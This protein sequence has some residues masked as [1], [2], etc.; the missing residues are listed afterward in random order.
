MS[1]GRRTY[2]VQAGPA[3]SEREGEI[4]RLVVHSFIET[5]GP[6]GSSFLANRYG[7]GLSTA[8]IRNTLSGLEARGFLNHPYTSAGRVPTDLG[9][10]TFV[11]R[12]MQAT[13]LSQR[14]QQVMESVVARADALN[15]GYLRECSRLLGRFSNL[16]GVV[17]SPN[18]ATGIL[19]RLEVV[20]V[21][22]DRIM[23]VISLQ[24]GLLKTVVLELDS[25]LARKDLERAVTLLNERLSG[26]T[27]EEIRSTFADRIGDLATEERSGIVRLALEKSDTLFSE[28]ERTRLTYSGAEQLLDQPEFQEQP[29]DLRKLIALLEEENFVVQFLEDEQAMPAVAQ[30]TIRIGS[31]NSDEKV[32]AYSII[33]A[34]Y[35][36]GN[37]VGTLGVIGPTRMD[38]VRVIPLVEEMASLMSRST[39]GAGH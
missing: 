9:Y 24:G 6:I 36:L 11:D 7:I 8:S 17:L 4:L 31:E 3:L 5:A 32:D 20:P 10:R 19:E 1:K 21:S 29:E 12:L 26:L 13:T 30:A 22:S 14:E 38:Y 15:E 27:L 25:V 16:L 2:E 33:T 39:G 28:H 23:F 18:L 34:Q 35:Q 37:S